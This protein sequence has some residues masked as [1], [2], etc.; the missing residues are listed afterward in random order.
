MIRA[1]TSQNTAMIKRNT[2]RLKTAREVLE[3]SNSGWAKGQRHSFSNAD[4]YMR[5]RLN[6]D[7]LN[8]Q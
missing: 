4:G 2:L 3:N 8:K 6:V 1:T 5:S 7:S